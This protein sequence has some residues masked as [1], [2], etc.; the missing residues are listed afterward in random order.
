MKNSTFEEIGNV[1][2]SASKILIFPHLNIDGDALGS[3][4]AL[5]G[6]LKKIGKDAKILIADKLPENISFLDK[7]YC[8]TEAEGLGAFDVSVCVDGGDLK[9]IAGNTTVF[10]RGKISVCI[11]HHMTTEPL[12][13][14]NYIDSS[15]SATGE[16][17]YDLIKVMGISIDKEIGEAL[18]AA[19]VTDT[20][21]FQYSN[22]TGK[23]LKKVAEL[24]DIGID[25][26]NVSVEIYEKVPLRKIKIKNIA[27][28]TLAVFSDGK[29]ALAYVT[30]EMLSD[31]EADMEDTDGV[32]EEL[33]TIEKVEISGLL[34]EIDRDTIKVSLRVK[35]Y[36]NVAEIAQKFGGGGHEKAAGFTLN[37]S[38]SCAFDIVK[39]E[40]IENLNKYDN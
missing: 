28:N 1:L 15:A 38:L 8:I 30:Q 31:A 16:L 33:R 32:A 4:V 11:D 36:G 35:H 25:A 2:L 39:R 17:I 23:T 34:K 40:I 27:M 5:C 29:G 22:T 12:C 14:Y 26:N 7:G 24:Y 9:R 20:G 19:I 21:K 3:S 18:Y 6:A 13:D 10:D 37:C